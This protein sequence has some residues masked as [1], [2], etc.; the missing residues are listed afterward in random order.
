MS[1]AS[2]LSISVE[3]AQDVS[4]AARRT[5]LKALNG[6]VLGTPVDKGEARGGWQVSISTPILTE[7]EAID[8]SGG[9]TINKGVSTI[10]SAKTIKYP[11]I[12]IV[13]NV[14]HITALNNGHSLQA[15]KKFVETAIKRAIR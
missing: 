7:S 5:A 15:P 4:Q 8:R 11:T 9:L 12:W 14:K 1:N 3:L 10:E 2:D 6:V 13:N